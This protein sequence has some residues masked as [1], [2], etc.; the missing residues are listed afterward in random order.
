[1]IGAEALATVDRVLHNPT[2]LS[3]A[4][5]GTSRTVRKKTGEHDGNECHFGW[6][7]DLLGLASVWTHFGFASLFSPTTTA[8]RVSTV[9]SLP[10]TS[11]WEDLAMIFKRPFPPQTSTG[12]R[13][14]FVGNFTH[15]DPIMSD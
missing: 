14:P 2:T 11:F 12:R 10:S 13:I 1:M 4:S 9:L 7:L 8:N 6:T 5:W 3:T 15:L